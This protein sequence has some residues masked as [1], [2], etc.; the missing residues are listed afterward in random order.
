MKELVGTTQEPDHLSTR[1][2]VQDITGQP[3][4]QTQ[5]LMSKFVINVSGSVISQAAVEVPHP[6]DGP[7]VIR[8]MG[9][10]HLGSFSS[11][12]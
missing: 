9:P 6:H 3:S 8:S 5:K 1:S 2:S 4:R 7:M 11:R 10:R 12:N